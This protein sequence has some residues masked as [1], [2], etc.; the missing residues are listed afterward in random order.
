MKTLYLKGYK[1]LLSQNQR[2]RI[3]FLGYTWYEAVAKYIKFF[4]KKPLN[5]KDVNALTKKL[6][7]V[8]KTNCC[9]LIL[10]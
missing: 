7:P 1:W 3:D 10:F 5:L 2:V 8:S 9:V 4:L 6:I